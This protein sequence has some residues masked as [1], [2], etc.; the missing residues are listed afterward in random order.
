MCDEEHYLTLNRAELLP[1]MCD[2][3]HNVCRFSQIIGRFSIKLARIVTNFWPSYSCSSNGSVQM[4]RQVSRLC[5][6]QF[7]HAS[8][9]GRP[10]LQEGSCQI[11]PMVLLSVVVRHRPRLSP[12]AQLT[13]VGQ[14]AV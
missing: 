3:H 6:S 2:N 5:K 7:M 14:A 10:G 12:R 9:D 4:A 13:D 11:G 8:M 1:N